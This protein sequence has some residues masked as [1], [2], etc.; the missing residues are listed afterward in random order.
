MHHIG[1]FTDHVDKF[2]LKVDMKREL[3]G[4]ASATEHTDLYKDVNYLKMTLDPLLKN[5]HVLT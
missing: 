5:A 4:K 1:K 2:A 3:E